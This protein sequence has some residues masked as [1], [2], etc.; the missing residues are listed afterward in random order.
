[1]GYITMLAIDELKPELE[2]IAAFFPIIESDLI[3]KSN[4]KGKSTG[5]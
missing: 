3:R 1:M 2:A 4:D 5:N